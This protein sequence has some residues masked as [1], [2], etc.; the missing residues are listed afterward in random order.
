[1]LHAIPKLITGRFALATAIATGLLLAGCGGGGTSSSAGGGATGATTVSGVV[2]NGDIAS[3]DVQPVTRGTT[4]ER[5]LASLANWIS[6]TAHAAPVP[7]VEV[8]LVCESGFTGT[9]T[10]DADGVFVIAGVPADDSC[11]LEVDGFTA[12]VVQTS[13]N[14]VVNVNVTISPS[15]VEDTT[16][17]VRGTVSDD[18][19]TALVP[20]GHFPPPGLCRLWFVNRPAGQ[21][22]PPGDCLEVE[23]RQ[24]ELQALGEEVIVVRS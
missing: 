13:P 5:L 1:M 22:P 21:Q 15:G 18:E 20:P 7:G 9:D 2:D 16:V 19:T 24:F 17:V 10:T 3:L 12:T 11:S 23:E 14:T 4:G 8:V 6:T